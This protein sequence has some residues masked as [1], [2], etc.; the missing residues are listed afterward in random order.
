MSNKSVS[1]YFLVKFHFLL[2]HKW[3]KI[4]FSTRKKFKTV[5]IAISQKIVLIYL[6]SRVFLPGIFSIV[7][8]VVCLFITFKDLLVIHNIFNFVFICYRS[9]VSS[10][11]CW[12]CL[13]SVNWSRISTSW[14]G[15]SPKFWASLSS[16]L[17]K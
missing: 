6:I 10:F 2:F 12:S 5:K 8:P 9:R 11:S 17:F 7:W 13:S 1:R 15:I 3:P 14:S 4:N 16:C